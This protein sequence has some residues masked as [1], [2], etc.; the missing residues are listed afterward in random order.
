[1][2]IQASVN[3]LTLTSSYP[4]GSGDP[5]GAF[6]ATSVAQLREAG[7]RVEIGQLHFTGEESILERLRRRPWQ[8]PEFA[9]RTLKALRNI[10]DYDRVVCHW[11]WPF[12]QLALLR[13]VPKEKI[14]IW[15]HGSGL[16]LLHGSGLETLIP[17]AS[18]AIVAEHQRR[19]LPSRLQKSAPVI[20]APIAPK[21]PRHSGPV[22]KKI[23]FIGRLTWNKGADLLPGILDLLPG[24]QAVVV[25]WGA[26]APKLQAD[27]R[28]QWL[29]ALPSPEWTEHVGR[30]VAMI[31]S[32]VPEGAPLVL[33]EF[34]SLGLP[35]VARDLRGLREP[36]QSN[37]LGALVRSDRPRE[38]A[39]ACEHV[40]T[41]KLP[42]WQAT[43]HASAWRQF[44][45]NDHDAIHHKNGAHPGS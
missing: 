12:P 24:W 45:V 44:V 14:R 10:Q 19:L 13:G 5:R 8:A 2:S 31:P 4:S 43:C 22:D 29:G 21:F 9:A 25:G 3:I 20:P 36:I 16:R 11:A 6:V 28:I 39:K 17:Q 32:R 26:L 27:P 30:G 1:R 18:T 35:V 7:H 40:Q 15:C 23:I 37:G 34:R 33:R 38:W 42:E 41:W